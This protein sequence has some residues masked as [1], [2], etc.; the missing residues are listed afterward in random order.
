MISVNDFK[1]RTLDAIEK[2]YAEAICG[3]FP[4]YMDFWDT[5]VG[6]KYDSYTGAIVHYPLEFP[7]IFKDNINKCREKIE[8]IFQANYTIFTNL[9]GTHFQLSNLRDALKLN[10]A[11]INR[12]FW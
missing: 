10:L 3:T 9:A 12:H 4:K 8:N 7:G 1:E 5:F 2:R 6:G 11:D